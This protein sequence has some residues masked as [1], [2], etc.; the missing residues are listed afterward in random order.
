MCP[1]SVG[2]P[3][4]SSCRSVIAGYCSGLAQWR[5]VVVIATPYP[6]V[7]TRSFVWQFQC[8]PN[9]YANNDICVHIHATGVVGWARPSQWEQKLLSP[10]LPPWS[11]I[12]SLEVRW[13][14]AHVD[15]DWMSMQNK[16]FNLAEIE[17]DCHAQLIM[18]ISRI[19]WRKRTI[20]LVGWTV[21]YSRGGREECFQ[22]VIQMSLW[23]YDS[24][25]SIWPGMGI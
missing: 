4:C 5:T 6:T 17:V 16:Q 24:L 11:A 21:M 18:A 9:V 1:S 10:C 14:W 2:P 3:S 23:F 12:S 15:D 13:W 25:V 22:F 19:H 7:I 8:L 20:G